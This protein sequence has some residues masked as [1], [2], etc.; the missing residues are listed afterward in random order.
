[1]ISVTRLNGQP[2]LLNVLLIEKVEALPDTTI[3]LISGKKLVVSDQLDHVGALINKRM[4]EFGLIGSY[5]KEDS[6][7][8]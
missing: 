2:M 8:T 7:L 6:T 4:S 3:T 5:K 1:M